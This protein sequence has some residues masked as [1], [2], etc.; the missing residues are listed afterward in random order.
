[1]IRAN[2]SGLVISRKRKL[3]CLE[4]K[5]RQQQ[6]KWISFFV[7]RLNFSLP[8]SLSSPEPSNNSGVLTSGD[9]HP[10]CSPRK[11]Q[12]KQAATVRYQG[13]RFG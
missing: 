9:K 8:P 12:N 1:M 4:I 5:I 6:V 7:A 11:L 2:R 10:R 3:S 13:I